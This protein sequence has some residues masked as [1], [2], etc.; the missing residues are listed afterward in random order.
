MYSQALVAVAFV[1]VCVWYYY[2]WT[3]RKPT[4]NSTAKQQPSRKHTR[5]RRKRQSEKHV[6]D[7]PPIPPQPI[8]VFLVLDVEATCQ[9]GVDFNYPNEIIVRD[10]PTLLI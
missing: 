5:S 2:Y 8:D 7:E 10:Y 1:T 6:A 4:L 9:Q 3:P